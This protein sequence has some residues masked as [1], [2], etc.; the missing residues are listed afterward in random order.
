MSSYESKYSEQGLAGH[1]LFRQALGATEEG[2]HHTEFNSKYAEPDA[3]SAASEQLLARRNDERRP[4]VEALAAYKQ[5]VAVTEAA[6]SAEAAP[7]PSSGLASILANLRQVFAANGVR[8]FRMCRIKFNSMTYTHKNRLS[9]AELKTGLSEFFG[10]MMPSAQ[11]DALFAFLDNDKDGSIQL[12]EL[13][14]GLQGAMNARRTAF[15][16][17]AFDVL[18]SDGDGVVTLADVA[19]VRV[20]CTCTSIQFSVAKYVYVP[21]VQTFFCTDT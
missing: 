11:L 6:R 18:D 14:A 8:T 3:A 17:R 7:L 13:W 10:L 2:A 9:K 15:V 21:L 1:A 16:D 12:Q 19:Q 5:T 20:T 4:S